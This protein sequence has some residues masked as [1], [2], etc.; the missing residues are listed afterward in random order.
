MSA[1]STVLRK[2]MLGPVLF[3]VCTLA[4]AQSIEFD[5][6]GMYFTNT[7]PGSTSAPIVRSVIN[8]S[9]VDVTLTAVVLPSNP[10]F[11]ITHNCPL[12][13]LVLA[14]GASCQIT[15]TFTAPAAAGTSEGFVRVEGTGVSTIALTLNGSSSGAVASSHPVPA[16]GPLALA[17]G[18]FAIAALGFA[19]K[20][21]RPKQDSKGRG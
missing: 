4:S 3:G 20:R 11:N 7:A 1:I 16:T 5:V 14:G 10:P 17:F 13:P 15:G 2:A 19:T 9:A 6:W 12:A 8:S 18:S 21:R